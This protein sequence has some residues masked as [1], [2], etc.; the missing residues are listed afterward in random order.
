MTTKPEEKVTH[1]GGGEGEG[2]EL[3]EGGVRQDSNV[4]VNEETGIVEQWKG[5]DN[6]NDSDDDDDD[7]DGFCDDDGEDYYA[8]V[9]FMFEGNQP[10]KLVELKWQYNQ[11]MNSSSSHS[12]QRSLDDSGT[13]TMT[14]ST[15]RVSLHCI[16]DTPGAVQ[17]GHYLW[18]GAQSMADFLLSEKE[19]IEQHE[20]KQKQNVVGVIELGAGCALLSLFLLQLYCTSIQCILVTD[21]DPGTLVRATDNHETTLQTILDINTTATS[22]TSTTENENSLVEQRQKD[23]NNND[24]KLNSIINNLASIPILFEQLEWGS[25]FATIEFLYHKMLDY[26]TFASSSKTI[27]ND[28]PVDSNNNDTNEDCW[29]IVGSDLIY[30]ADVV[31]PLF[32]TVSTFMQLIRK[33]HQQV[34]IRFLLS[35]SFL[36]DDTTEQAIIDSCNEFQLERT[37]LLFQEH[38]V[39][40]DGATEINQDDDEKIKNTGSKYCKIQEFVP[41]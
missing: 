24:T 17:S 12:I 29:L 19:Q 28:T 23:D 38:G 34:K 25:D 21:H 35:Q 18:P 26:I 10:V 8:D 1:G 2:P 31:R 30:C 11:Q 36:Y 14:P 7:D 4:L 3:V 40:Q 37:V 39:K 15:I 20:R 16:N 41:K 9:G 27:Q 13:S 5:D 33:Q 32:E 6:S 22:T